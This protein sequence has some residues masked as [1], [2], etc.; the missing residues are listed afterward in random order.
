M[1]QSKYI[2]VSEA[3]EHKRK[4]NKIAYSLAYFKSLTFKDDWYVVKHNE[5][6]FSRTKG[7]EQA[8]N[9]YNSIV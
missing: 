6:E 9:E 1:I 4:G 7:I 8:V 3:K 5:T 2:T